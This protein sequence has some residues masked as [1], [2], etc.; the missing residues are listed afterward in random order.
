MYKNND[1][2]LPCIYSSCVFLHIKNHQCLPSK[3]VKGKKWGKKK[4]KR[5][6]PSEMRKQ[7][8]S[9]MFIQILNE[10]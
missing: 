9:T 7:P 8:N 4:N 10:E 3:Q 5:K 1:T 2:T 6:L